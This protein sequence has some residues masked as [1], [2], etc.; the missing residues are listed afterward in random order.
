MRPL[1]FSAA[2]FE[3]EPSLEVLKNKYGSVDYFE[4]GIG[5]LA[6]AKSEAHLQ[7]VCAGRIVYFVGSCGAFYPFHELHLVT[8]D[9]VYWMPTCVRMGLGGFPESLF[10]KKSLSTKLDL[11]KKSVL[12]SVSV[13]LSCEI[14]ETVAKTLPPKDQLVENMEL[15]A[16]VDALAKAEEIHI[17][18][19]VTNQVGNKGRLQWAENFQRVAELT[20]EFIRRNC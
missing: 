6:A 8:V 10:P 19:G 13:S 17:I 15:Y 14:S 7:E 4:I 20:A 1:L 12:T 9:T 3:A 18:L 11:P 16:C 2:R 5:P